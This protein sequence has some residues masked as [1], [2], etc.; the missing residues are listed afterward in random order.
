MTYLGGHVSRCCAKHFLY[1]HGRCW[2]AGQRQA[3]VLNLLTIGEA[4][5]RIVNEC[6]EFATAHP[7]I[8]WAQMRG[9]RN[10]M[11]HG[12][13]DVDL[14]IVWDTVQSSLPD[15]ERLLENAT[16]PTKS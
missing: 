13:F 3:V 4:A 12:Y 1:E 10:R 9:M 5:G 15:L 14:N 2:P 16:T 7:E 11:A 6:K 8:P